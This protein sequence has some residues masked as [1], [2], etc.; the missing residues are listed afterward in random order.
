[1]PERYT[2]VP[3]ASLPNKNIPVPNTPQQRTE[4]GDYIDTAFAEE[5]NWLQN[6]N[7][8]IQAESLEN[9]TRFSWAAFHCSEGLRQKAIAA[10]SAVS[11]LLPLFPDEAKSVA[12][13][14]HSLNVIK[15]S[16]EYINPGQIPVIAFDQPLYALAKKIQWN[17]RDIYGEQKFLAMFG[18][19]HI[20][21]AF[22]KTLESLLEDSGWTAALVDADVATA[23]TA[24]L[25]TK[26]ANIKRTR[27]A[28]QVTVSALCALLQS[29]YAKYQQDFDDDDCAFSFDDWCAQKVLQVPQFH[30]WYLT[31]Q[32]ELLL[33]IFLRSIRQA[34]F[35][36]HVDS[37][38]KMLQ[39][40][41]AL[42]HHNYARWL[43]VHLLD[44]RALPQTAPDVARR[45][46]D[47]FFT[48]NK[49]SKRFSAIAID[50]AHEQNNAIV[51]GD[52]GAVGLRR[53]TEN[54]S[55]L[56]R[57]MVSGPEIA[58]VV[59][60]FENEMKVASSNDV[61]TDHH[62]EMSKMSSH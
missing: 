61:K 50:Q 2:Q 26:I 11:A 16:V 49:S 3:P 23:G 54:P 14:K 37:I 47:G 42:N 53:L 32:L 34:N 29:A 24:G 39:W 18:G 9:K 10:S 8:L 59:N 21:Q 22:L 48:V 41:F 57:W 17:W 7:S 19:L 51:K 20:E 36:L 33:L 58:R 6:V 30:F 35:S 55:A 62:G 46:D 56:R 1:M 43:S 44:M 25:F 31:M 4:D 40:F 12:M 13:I 28:H 15:A 27:K 45:F 60:E 52:G 5:F 38:A